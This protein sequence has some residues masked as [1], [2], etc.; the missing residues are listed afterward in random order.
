MQGSSTRPLVSWKTALCH[1]KNLEQGTLPETNAYKVNGKPI[2]QDMSPCITARQRTTRR[3]RKTG[4]FRRTAA[5][6]SP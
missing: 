3:N 6:A 1:G 5:G 2:A 4:R